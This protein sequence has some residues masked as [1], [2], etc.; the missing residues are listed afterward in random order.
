MAVDMIGYVDADRARN[1]AMRHA[2]TGYIFA[3]NGTAV[4]WASQRKSVVALWTC[5][6]EYI[7]MAAA[8]KE[9][10]SLRTFLRELGF[11]GGAMHVRSDNQGA[12]K[13]AESEEH[14]RRTK[15]IDVRFRFLR[16]VVTNESLQ[17]KYVTTEENVA[18][19]LTKELFRQ[20]FERLRSL[21]GLI[22]RNEFEWECCYAS[23]KLRY[24]FMLR[25]TVPWFL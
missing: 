19:V 2:M 20:R 4:T 23:S 16:D 18:N 25:I 14:H 15:H 12:L 6:A 17:L 8:A 1:H 11:E 13:L 24:R 10:L 7:A 21:M 3:L 9:I 5:K 22:M